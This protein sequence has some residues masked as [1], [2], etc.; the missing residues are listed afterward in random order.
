MDEPD[1]LERI[2]QLATL[3]FTVAEIANATGVRQAALEDSRTPEGTAVKRGRFE[4]EVA[5]R[6]ALLKSARDG[7]HQAL[8]AFAQL[9]KR[10]AREDK[11]R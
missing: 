9:T 10:R 6:A 1:P 5:V 7:Q 11:G 4:A 8:N 2:T 3:Q